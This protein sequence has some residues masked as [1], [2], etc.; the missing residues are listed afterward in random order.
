MRNNIK[1]K[2]TIKIERENILT[3]R[4]S[5]VKTMY[6]LNSKGNPNDEIQIIILFWK[7]RQRE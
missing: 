5:R 7:N 2:K 4:V 1:K 3:I 6:S